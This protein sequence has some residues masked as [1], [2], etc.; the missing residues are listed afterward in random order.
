MRR[1]KDE[2]VTKFENCWSSAD[3]IIC[4]NGKRLS[5]YYDDDEFY[6]DGEIY[7]P[8]Q[9]WKDFAEEGIVIAYFQEEK[10][11][12]DLWEYLDLQK[13]IVCGYGIRF[14]QKEIYA[15]MLNFIGED[16]DGI[17]DYLEFARRYE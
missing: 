5:N 8:L 16:E 12:G 7:I 4:E 2:I 10:L 6:T 15:E 9:E 3:D 13:S 1:T 17:C 14:E 11:W